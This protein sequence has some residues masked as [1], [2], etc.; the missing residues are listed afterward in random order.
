M[1]ER[2]SSNVEDSGS[3]ILQRLN[4]WRAEEADMDLSVFP[5]EPA[6]DISSLDDIEFLRGF[7]DWYNHELLHTQFKYMESLIVITE[8]LLTFPVL[9]GITFPAHRDYIRMYRSAA[10]ACMSQAKYS[11]SERLYERSMHYSNLLYQRDER[12]YKTLMVDTANLAAVYIKEERYREAE[13]LLKNCL[14]YWESPIHSNS[15]ACRSLYS[16]YV[17]VLLGQKRF[18]E[19]EI[20]AD[21]LLCEDE[22]LL[23]GVNTSDRMEMI[24]HDLQMAKALL[25]QEQTIEARLHFDHGVEVFYEISEWER[26]KENV[27]ILQ[28]R[29]F[30]DYAEFLIA[31]NDR[32][33]ALEALRTAY[34]TGRDLAANH[35]TLFAD[36][37]AHTA[38]TYGSIADTEEKV[39]VYEDMT[40]QLHFINIGLPTPCCQREMA[41][42]YYELAK[43][44]EAQHELQE[45]EKCFWDA[46]EI[47][48]YLPERDVLF[49]DVAYEF[50]HLLSS[51]H[52]MTATRLSQMLLHSASRIREQD[53]SYTDEECQVF[54]REA[55]A[56]FQWLSDDIAE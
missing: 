44:Y 15:L 12:Y 31:E 53:E 17:T 36:R 30:C 28:F 1:D 29:L 26:K 6:W 39:A 49:A 22:S 43:I 48:E 45:A 33:E 47:L 35:P 38:I 5:D 9:T 4:A 2:K 27:V 25:G 8:A 3:V 21:Q 18:E 56:W 24:Y 20:L 46:Y 40:L 34:S 51:Q 55:D 23:F 14:R 13:V 54:D 52:T 50:A 10:A 37:F 32:E 7:Y 41:S 16:N 42:A 11:L 19:A